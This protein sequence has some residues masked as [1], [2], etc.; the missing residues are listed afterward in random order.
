MDIGKAY[1]DNHKDTIIVSNN[2][3]FEYDDTIKVWHGMHDD[4]MII[5]M[6]DYLVQYYEGYQCT[7][8]KLMKIPFRTKLWKL[9]KPLFVNDNIKLNRLVGYLPINNN[10]V[11]NLRNGEVVDREKEHYF[12]YELDVDYVRN[13]PISDYF[14]GCMRD[15]SKIQKSLGYCMT[16]EGYYKFMFCGTDVYTDA[17]RLMSG[18]LSKMKWFV[19]DEDYKRKLKRAGR[20]YLGLRVAVLGDMNLAL[21]RDNGTA[22]VTRCSRDY[23]RSED[24]EGVIYLDLYDYDNV[25]SCTTKEI[26]DFG[27][28]SSDIFSWMV[29]GAIR[30][31]EEGF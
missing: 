12:T 21:D 25:D 23:E 30:Y 18:V 7:I 17:L 10:K 8:I 26:I 20:E 9:I 19:N 4:E 2:H 3:C 28:G 14:F 15:V 16:G 13:T 5:E 11:I 27:G 22:F 29:K 24:V 31:Y 6:R 1:Y